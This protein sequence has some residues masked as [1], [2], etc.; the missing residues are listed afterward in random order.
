MAKQKPTTL[1][2]TILNDLRQNIL[3]GLWPPG[4]VIPSEVELAA[5]HGVSRMTMNK[6]LAQL[7]RAGMVERKRKFGTVV[8]LPRVQSAAMEIVDIEREISSLGWHYSY[9]L[10]SSAPRPA[11]DEDVERL[12]VRQG[13]RILAVQALH[14]ADDVPFCS[15][16]RLVNLGAVPAA[17]KFDFSSE[18]PGHWLLRQV[19]WTSAEHRF[20]AVN[21]SAALAANLAV[22]TG[23][24]C[25]VVERLTELEG[26]PV[27]WVRFSY[28]GDK[29]QL[30]ARFAP[31]SL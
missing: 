9:K 4:H 12:G 14:M 30:S 6:V 28:P 26:T 24:A 3:S 23:V 31:H 21:A 18:A 16:E 11:S 17:A 15:E 8:C 22:K 5:Q 19:P 2:E 29:H 1:H 27:T 10:I 13:A 25:L 7:A 20:S